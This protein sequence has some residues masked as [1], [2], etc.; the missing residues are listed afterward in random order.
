MFDRKPPVF[1][2]YECL[3]PL[4]RGGM[5][6]VWVARARG[7]RGFEKLLA[8]KTMLPAMLDDPQAETM[9]LD[10][11]RLAAR[12]RHPNVTEIFDLGE[13]AGQLFI[14][15]DWID[16][17]SAAGLSRALNAP[18]PLP[19]A[20]HIAIEA[21]KGLH[22]AHELLGPDGQ[23]MGL[24]HRDVSPHNVLLSRTGLVVLSDFGIAKALG[25]TSR[26]ETG[27]V[28]GK[29]GY[30]APEQAMGGVVDRRADVF[31]LGVVLYELTTR[32]HPFRGNNAIET[33]ERL[34]RRP[35]VPP[36]AHVAGLP[37]E[38]DAV[39]LRALERDPDARYSTAEELAA[40][41]ARVA[42][43]S[44]G[45]ASAAQLGEFLQAHLGP[46][47]ALRDAALHAA[48][49]GAAASEARPAAALE[50]LPATA[51]A[52]LAQEGVPKGVAVTQVSLSRVLPAS[53][54]ASARGKLVAMAM[55]LLALA[56]AGYWWRS[57]H[58]A[59]DAAALP[60]RSAA[61]VAVSALP[62]ATA[63][64][65]SPSTITSAGPAVG[66]P[67]TTPSAA[68]GARN[69]KPVLVPRARSSSTAERLP[70]GGAR[71]SK[72][73]VRDPGF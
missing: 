53:E 25:H 58:L 42:R 44:V 22:A 14:A 3:V 45:E 43:G 27:V 29:P 2:R 28:K 30:M 18:M 65:P 7:A 46:Q 62:S 15:M 11:A 12:I 4:G 40:E 59:A 17:D 56:G 39:I 38:L 48:M 37:R 61:S 47:L 1:G 8:I 68:P 57:E 72:V 10:E 70:P 19:L 36:S 23:P 67:A 73:P 31:A 54:P 20:L 32:Q 49:S 51:R 60:P 55:L 9:F 26:T 33:A 35:F 50:P 66:Q 5:A 41:L 13:E 34:L 24:V 52:P 16:G 6:E 69:P 71:P 64:Q 63:N 21:G